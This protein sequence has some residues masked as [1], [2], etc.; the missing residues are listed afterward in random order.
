MKN[1]ALLLLLLTGCGLAPAGSQD[2]PLSISAT[3]D[4]GAAPSVNNGPIPHT[5]RV[6]FYAG[7]NGG[8]DY[9][10]GF[11]GIIALH[12]GTLTSADDMVCWPTADC[13]GILYHQIIYTGDGFPRTTTQTYVIE[14]TTTDDVFVDVGTKTGG[15]TS[16]QARIY[17]DGVLA[18]QFV[19]AGENAT[20]EHR[21]HILSGN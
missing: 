4:P 15:S 18:A 16:G 12:P 8:Q 6:E 13:S 7:F 9:L 14:L 11:S 5:Y 20:A 2:Q 10:E 21:Y 3:V 19:G 17:K 1:V